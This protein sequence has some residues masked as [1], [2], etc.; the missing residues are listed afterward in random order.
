MHLMHVDRFYERGEGRFD[1]QRYFRRV[2]LTKQV[3]AELR[4]LGGAVGE[5]CGWPTRGARTNSWPRR[6]SLARQWKRP[7]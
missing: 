3:E 5:A 6:A 7:L 1:W 2:D 4:N